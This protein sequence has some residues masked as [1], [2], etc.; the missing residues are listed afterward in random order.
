MCNGASS[1]SLSKTEQLRCVNDKNE[2]IESNLKL[3][4]RFPMNTDVTETKGRTGFSNY[5][6][7]GYVTILDNVTVA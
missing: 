6:N 4:T 5:E 2:W 7:A 1:P 3:S